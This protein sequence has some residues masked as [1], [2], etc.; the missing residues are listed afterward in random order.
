MRQERLRSDLEFDKIFEECKSLQQK[1]DIAEPELPRY[2]LPPRR[3]DNGVKPVRWNT[4]RDMYNMFYCEIMDIIRVSLK[5]RFTQP[6]FTLAKQMESILLDA[7]QGKEI[8]S[9]SFTAVVDHFGSDTDVDELKLN[10][11]ML[12]SLCDLSKLTDKP[13]DVTVICNALNSLGPAKKLYKQVNML[14]RLFLVLPV[15]S[16]SAERSFS[17]MRRL[18]NYLRK[19]MTTERLNTCAILHVHYEVSGELDIKACVREF[20]S[21]CENRTRVFGVVK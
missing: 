15:S 8:D 10:L 17:A 11:S 16:A 6:S 13:A 19:T 3:I 4:P 20:V 21:R 18:R 5:D 14:I 2:G 1:L 7:A 9:E 12:P